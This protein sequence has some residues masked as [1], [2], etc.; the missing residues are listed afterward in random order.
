TWRPETPGT[1]PAARFKWQSVADSRLRV[2]GGLELNWLGLGVRQEGLRVTPGKFCPS[3]S[4]LTHAHCPRCRPIK[5]ENVS[6]CPETA[7]SGV[8][9]RR[10]RDS[11]RSR[12]ACAR[13]IPP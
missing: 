10:R 5:Y 9:L 13:E 2:S 8:T 1:W 3:Y 6:P 7:H 12:R 4:G 11:S